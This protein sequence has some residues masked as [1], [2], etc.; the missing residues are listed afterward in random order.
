MSTREKWADRID[1]AHT[2]LHHLVTNAL[3]LLV[4]S[5]AL[6]LDNTVVC[7]LHCDRLTMLMMLLLPP[8]N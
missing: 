8:A 2:A 4:E 3:V 1:I 7:V 6:C 5:Q